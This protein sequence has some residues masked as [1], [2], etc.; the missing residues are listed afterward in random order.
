MTPAWEVL[1][2]NMVDKT[3]CL[4]RIEFELLPKSPMN[5]AIKRTKCSLNFDKVLWN[6][7]SA[8]VVVLI[9]PKNACLIMLSSIYL[10][11]VTRLQCHCCVSN[12]ERFLLKNKV[13]YFAVKFDSNHQIGLQ[14]SHSIRNDTFI[15]YI[16]RKHAT[17]LPTGLAPQNLRVDVFFVSYVR[18]NSS[19][20]SS[21]SKA[22]WK[23][24]KRMD[25]IE[26][27]LKMLQLKKKLPINSNK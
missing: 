16:Q 12:L 5:Q 7:L 24:L 27:Q 11:A 1:G 13:V 22:W 23:A 6:G 9:W 15:K 25:S 19:V 17:L 10:I 3:T 21:I 18:S 26:F 20:F 2:S 4:K 14:M 8:K